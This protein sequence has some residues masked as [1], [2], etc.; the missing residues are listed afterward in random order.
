MSLYISFASNFLFN[1][2]RFVK[3]ESPDK[4]LAPYQIYAQVKKT[5]KPHRKEND[6]KKERIS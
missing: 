3:E 1:F 2:D 5:P 6:T 4:G